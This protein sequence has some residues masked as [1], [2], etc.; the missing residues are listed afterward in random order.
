MPEISRVVVGQP[1]AYINDPHIW[2][3][4]RAV[5][6]IRF[7]M[8][9]ALVRYDRN[10]QFIPSLAERWTLA[11]DARTWTFEL[12]RGVRFHHGAEFTAE[13]AAAS[14][15]RAVSPEM[16]G[17][18]GTAALLSGY[19]QTAEIKVLDPYQLQIVTA[20]PMA[21]LLDLLVY[22]MMVPASE[23][24][25]VSP[26][27]PGTG[28][29][30]FGEAE[31]GLVQLKR[32]DA[33]WAGPA[34]VETLVFQT[35]AEEE[36]RVAAF[37]KG[38]VDVITYISPDQLENLEKSPRAHC[39][40]RPTTVCVIM[41]FN[42]MQGVCQDA[43]V[44]R[45]LNYATRM[46]DIVRDV[47]GGHA[48]RLNGPLTQNHIG[49]D[50]TLEPYS[51]DPEKA[52]ALLAEAGYAQGLTLLLDRPSELPDESAQLAAC[53][54]KDWAAVGVELQERVHT[55]RKKYA[56]TVRAKNIADL[57]VFDSSPMSTYRVLREKLDSRY[58]GPWWEGYHNAEVNAL[59]DQAWATIDEKERAARYQEAYR[60]IA[61]DAPWIFFYNPLELLVADRS[62]LETL[63]QWGIGIDGLVLFGQGGL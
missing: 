48:L 12:R 33:Y 22:I 21:D 20:D 13:D 47:M 39:W 37:L 28:P 15:R 19:L 41:M 57:C 59:M 54:Q 55:D 49:C 51:Y 14:I 46:D 6:N 34:P 52:R 3:D 8:Y 17:E 43:R 16:P 23:I 61:H 45:A 50:T 5:L 30:R 24:D 32:F 27:S 56:E 18:Y 38:D 62:I 25:R 26:T 53:L 42:T 58:A 35:I 44:R 10:N 1:S 11:E 36:D 63:P 9:E 40:K 60:L 7:A 2:V 31:N 4:S 29:Y